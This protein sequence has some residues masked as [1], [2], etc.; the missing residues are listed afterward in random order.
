MSR[1][2]AISVALPVFNG[3][4]FLDEAIS[5]V[6]S[7]TFQNL[8]LIIAD[9]CSTDNS[10]AIARNWADRDSRIQIL[11]SHENLGAA[12]NFNRAFA[13]ASGEYFKWAACD[14]VLQT[15]FLQK[16]I[17]RFKKQPHVVLV[18]SD[19]LDIDENGQTIGPIYDS[20][21]RMEVDSEDPVVRFR[22]LVLPNHSCISVFGLI[23]HS[24]L[25]HTGLIGPFVGSDRVLLVQLALQ[26]PFSR[27]DEPL[28]LHR[29][30]AGRSTRSIPR[31]KDRAAWFDSSLSARRVFPHW[32]ILREYLSSLLKSELV[33]EH[34]IR[35]SLHVLR[36]IRWG[37]WR[38]LLDD[39]F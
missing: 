35:C 31:P 38:N 15:D 22:D 34:K 9:N 17:D 32:R 29:E 4:K 12:P 6:L 27:I 8:E 13:A 16:C 5:S 30:H 10:L 7:Q 24:V 3:E 20:N 21:V 36:W 14:D 26:G 11:E 23:R 19:A 18:Y 33:F 1:K 28:I 39:V 37:G 25:A 2:P